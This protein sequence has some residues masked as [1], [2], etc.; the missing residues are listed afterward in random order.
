MSSGPRR[1]EFVLFAAL[2]LVGLAVWFAVFPNMA[3]VIIGVNLPRWTLDNA[4][5]RLFLSPLVCGVL[6]LASGFVFPRGFYLWGLALA[7]HGPFVQGLTVYLMY[8]EGIELAEG[9][10]GIVSYGTISAVLFV[11][12]ILCY[13][14]LSSA[15]AGVRYLLTRGSRRRGSTQR[16]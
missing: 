11:F 4:F 13:T 10:R 15:G 9:P 1:Q 5:L 16:A 12:T 8:Q 3:S 14:L 7:L 6:A 2:I